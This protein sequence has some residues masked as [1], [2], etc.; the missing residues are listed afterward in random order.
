[1]FTN[2]EVRRQLGEV[3]TRDDILAILD[4]KPRL[5]APGA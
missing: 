1:M 2:C 3:E 5:A 4:S